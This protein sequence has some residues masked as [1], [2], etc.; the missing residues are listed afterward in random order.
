MN[1]I[2]RVAKACQL[3]TSTV[4]IIRRQGHSEEEFKTPTKRYSSSRTQ[5]H[6]DDFD[7]QAIRQS[8]HFMNATSTPR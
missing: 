5:I 8:M 7:R 4:A 2:E 6:V 3:S 1:A